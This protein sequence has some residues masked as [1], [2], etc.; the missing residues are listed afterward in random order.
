MAMFNMAREE[1]R[2]ERNKKKE[3]RKGLIYRYA[4]CCNFRIRL[5]SAVL[6]ASMRRLHAR[7]L[8]STLL[9]RTPSALIGLEFKK[10]LHIL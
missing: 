9:N 1:G 7:W 6:F 10:D 4:I 5:V 2:R 8:P 3:I